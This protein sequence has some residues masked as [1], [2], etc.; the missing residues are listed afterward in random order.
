MCSTFG[1][2]PAALYAAPKP[3]FGSPSGR[4]GSERDRGR[5]IGSLQPPEGRRLCVPRSAGVRRRYTRLRSPPSV[6]R[7]AALVPNEIGGGGSAAFNRLKEGDYV[8]HVRPVSGGVIR[9]SEALL[10]FTVRPPWFRTRSGAGDRQP[11]TA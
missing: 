5:G 4:P 6:H 11:S 8:F 10:R 3:S 2:C 7:P 9:G 1:R